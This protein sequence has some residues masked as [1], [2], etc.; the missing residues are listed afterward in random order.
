MTESPTPREMEC[1]TLFVRGM[2]AKDLGTHLNIGTSTVQNHIA[3]AYRKL[4]VSGRSAAARALG[5]DYLGQ[6]IP[7]APPP[8]PPPDAPVVGVDPPETKSGGSGLYELYVRLGNWRTPPRP[9]GGRFVLIFAG[10]MVVMAAVGAFFA[11]GAFV[12]GL[13]DLVHDMTR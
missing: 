4:G 5:I 9:R 10:A 12:Y 11:I 7:M 2:P 13:V 3:S 1:L 6:P 8:S